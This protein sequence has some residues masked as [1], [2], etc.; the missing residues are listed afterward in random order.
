ML[1]HISQELEVVDVAD[2]IQTVHLRETDKYVLRKRQR[3]A[4]SQKLELIVA[5]KAQIKH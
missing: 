4:F 3:A 5:F 1:N 2:K